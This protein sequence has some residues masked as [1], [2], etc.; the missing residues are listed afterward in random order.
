MTGN[1]TAMTRARRWTAKRSV[2][3]GAV[4]AAA[5]VIGGALVGGTGIHAGAYGTSHVYEITFA[6]Q[7]ENRTACVASDQN[8]FGIGGIW[9]WIEPDSGGTAEMQV[10]FQGHNNTDPSLNGTTHLSSPT[11]WSIVSLPTPNPFFSPPDPHGQYF[12]FGFGFL[13]PATPGHYQL[14]MGPGLSADITVTKLP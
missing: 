4:A 14:K 1:E 2:R 3:R 11:S 13:T 9:G 5:A 8:P 7:C 10:T 12:V 6:E